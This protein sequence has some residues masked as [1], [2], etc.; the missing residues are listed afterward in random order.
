MQ[1]SHASGFLSIDKKQAL[2]KMRE[3]TRKVQ[4]IIQ[5]DE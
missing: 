2:E 5:K 3:V 4:E 1:E